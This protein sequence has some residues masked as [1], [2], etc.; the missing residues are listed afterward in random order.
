MIV[1]APE[2]TLLERMPPADVR[3]EAGLIGCLLTEPSLSTVAQAV[4]PNIAAFS[5]ERHQI[6][7]QEITGLYAGGTNITA[8][9][10]YASLKKKN[11]LE[12]AGGLDYINHLVK[13]EPNTSG[14]EYYAGII[15]EH[16]HKR[17]LI[18]TFTD[19]IRDV[20]DSTEN[21]AQIKDR[22]LTKIFELEQQNN[23]HQATM[24]DVMHATFEQLE[25]AEQG[26]YGIPLPFLNLQNKTMGLHAGE[27]IVIAG[28]PGTGKSSFVQAI[29]EHAAIDCLKPVP[30]LVFSLEM[31]FEQ[32]G[33]R[34]ICARSGVEISKVK[35]GQIDRLERDRINRANSEI[36]NAPIYFDKTPGITPTDMRAKARRAVHDKGIGLVAIDYIGLMNC[37]KK[38]S[39]R[40]QEVAYISQQ[41]K[42][43]AQDLKL[44]VLALSQLNR[45]S[46]KDK[47]RPRSSDLRESG[48]LE[49]DADLIL[50]LHRE[51]KLYENDPDWQQQYPQ[52]Q[53]MAE[54]LIAKQRNGECGIIPLVF[55]GPTT[56][57]M[58]CSAAIAQGITV[59]LPA[60]M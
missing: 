53:H 29:I 43:M 4:L 16:Y 12:D 32:W 25:R 31:S 45:E 9:T 49:Q 19:G 22:A 33:L 54:V 48:S 1:E 42:Q 59:D 39:N 34:M 51:W 18:Q 47:R 27:S 6:L 14:A 60:G 23:S 40:E 44:P 20:F 41:C 35:R 50:L 7:F 30:C 55:Y 5:D 52:K 38:T 24:A 57:Y 26:D 15:A 56:R 36:C 11:R 10:V 37:G 46:E 3:I 13:L 17:T 28:R 58:D 21:A 2:N 8:M